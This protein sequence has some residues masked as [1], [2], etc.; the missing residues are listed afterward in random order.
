ME[1]KAPGAPQ[2]PKP[3]RDLDVLPAVALDQVDPPLLPPLEALQPV[4]CL[5]L[6]QVDLRE[7]IQGH[8]EAHASVDL[9][10]QIERPDAAEVAVGVT[11]QHREVET[12]DV[13]ADDSV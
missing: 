6:A 12:I 3:S 9:G 10:E 4:P 8:A 5:R 2:V 13:E 7:V 11:G 1:E